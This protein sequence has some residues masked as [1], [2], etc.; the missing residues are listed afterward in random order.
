MPGVTRT[1][2]AAA[3]NGTALLSLGWLLYLLPSAASPMCW[4]FAI[5]AISPE[6]A[7]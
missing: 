2:D 4:A 7:R 3:Y 5:F 1:L 6:P